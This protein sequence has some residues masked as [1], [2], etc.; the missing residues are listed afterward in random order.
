MM[1]YALN[2]LS[3]WLV[4]IA[5]VTA[6]ALTGYLLNRLRACKSASRRTSA[7]TRNKKILPNRL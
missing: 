1:I 7:P 2:I 6:T 5:A 3:H 4:V